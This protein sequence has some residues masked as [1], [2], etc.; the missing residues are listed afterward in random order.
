VNVIQTGSDV[1]VFTLKSNADGLDFSNPGGASWS[2]KFN[3]KDN[4]ATGVVG[5]AT[6]SLKRIGDH[7]FEETV[8]RESVLSAEDT[9]TVSDDGT[10]LTLLTNDLQHGATDTYFAHR[11]E[12]S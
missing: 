3:G 6:V 8:K 7:S 12:H 10:K 1:L 4:P 5:N 2:A 9:W 11:Q